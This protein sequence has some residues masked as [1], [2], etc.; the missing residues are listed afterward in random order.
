VNDITSKQT[1]FSAR[2]LEKTDAELVQACRRGDEAAWNTLVDR[3]QRLIITI[4]RR[5]GLSEEQAADVFQ[6][7]FLTLFE[8][9]DEI[10]QPGKIRS[11]MVTTAKFKTWGVVRSSKGFYQ[12]ETEE[13]ME[14]EMASLTDDAPL[15]DERLIEL[16]QQHQIRTALKQLEERCQ[17]ILSMIYLRDAAATYAE[18]ASAIGVGETSISPLRSR[19][20]QKLGKILKS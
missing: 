17:K 11:W 9:L 15:A 16:E 3:Y 1:N 10:E 5:A 20:L 6:E 8:K 2:A 4:P 12:P 14:L 13:E 7:V 18:V 19:C